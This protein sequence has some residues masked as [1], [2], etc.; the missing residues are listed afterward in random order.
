MESNEE[1]MTGRRDF[2]LTIKFHY[3]KKSQFLISE[4]YGSFSDTVLLRNEEKDQF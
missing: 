2:I 1:K 4:Y 3:Y